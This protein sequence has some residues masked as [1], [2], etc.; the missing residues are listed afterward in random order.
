[1]PDTNGLADWVIGELQNRYDTKLAQGWRPDSDER[2]QWIEEQVRPILERS[3]Q[4]TNRQFGADQ[5]EMN[6]AAANA[7][8]TTPGD[9]V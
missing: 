3:L 7:I 4:I 2:Y 8:S 6:F 5:R 1:M 9:P